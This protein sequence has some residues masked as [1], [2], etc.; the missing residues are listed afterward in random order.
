MLKGEGSDFMLRQSGRLE[1]EGTDFM[2]TSAKGSRAKTSY[3]RTAPSVVPRHADMA[4]RTYPTDHNRE[5]IAL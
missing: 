4:L 1:G 5:T 3:Y 2:C